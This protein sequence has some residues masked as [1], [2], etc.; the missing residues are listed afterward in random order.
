MRQG[1][2]WLPIRALV[3]FK[4][5]VVIPPIFFFAEQYC[6]RLGALARLWWFNGQQESW[7]GGFGATA[8]EKRSDT[9]RPC[10]QCGG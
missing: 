8:T 4:R 10:Y 6:K 1:A 2:D 5:T 3:R 7:S 9:D